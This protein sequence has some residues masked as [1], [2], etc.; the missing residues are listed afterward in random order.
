MGSL[1]NRG[2]ERRL[3]VAVSRARYEMIVFST[4][5]AE[6]I[7]LRRS[8]ALGVEGLQKFLKYA[9][10]GELVKSSTAAGA[11]AGSEDALAADIA[12]TLK[13]LGYET[14]TAVGRSL[15]KVDVAVIDPHDRERYLLGILIDNHARNATKIARDRELT[16]PS[17]LKGLGWRVL[18]VWSVDWM[19]N[20]QR[21]LDSIV[22]A[23]ETDGNTKDA[24]AAPLNLSAPKIVEEK[25]KAIK[26]AAV[27][28]KT[29]E[30]RDI[31]DI[32]ED[33]IDA[34]VLQIVKEQIAIPLDGI[35]L[36][37]N[38]M[39]GY[40]RRTQ[41]IDNAITRSVARLIASKQI[42]RD[43]ETIKAV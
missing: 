32:P 1:N 23:I 37:A 15:F 17:V 13:G 34:V 5:R 41:R 40:T 22:A 19:Q 27:M 29:G 42:H 36:A 7:D 3:N 14:T 38:R 26:P 25:A 33:K 30:R 4:L 39:L 31:D 8:Q 43:G 12:A 24:T 20:R 10:T 28:S 11:D 9:E 21:V 18:R 16:Q 6:Q 2:G 35:K